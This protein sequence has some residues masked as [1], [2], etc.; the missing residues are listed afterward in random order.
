MFSKLHLLLSYLSYAISSRHGKGRGIHS[1]F[2]YDF[3]SRI[4]FD[5]NPYSDYFI[6]DSIVY[7]LKRSD[8]VMPVH[9]FGAGSRKFETKYRSLKD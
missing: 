1:P 8:I 9:E 6:M 5:K 3:V 7:G 2:L 4:L